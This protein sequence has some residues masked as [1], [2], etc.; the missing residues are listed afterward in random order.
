MKAAVAAVRW[1]QPERLV[2]AVPVGS[3]ETRREFA[4]IAAEIVCARTPD[5]FAAVGQW[6]EDFRQ[7]TD[8]EVHELLHAAVWPELAGR[9]REA[10]S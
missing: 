9:P 10:V 8:R 2:G 6:Y 3:L 4:D 1:L 5:N 7:T